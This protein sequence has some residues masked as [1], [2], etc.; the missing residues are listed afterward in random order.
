MV[1]VFLAAMM[2]VATIEGTGVQLLQVV[3]SAILL[4]VVAAQVDGFLAE[5]PEAD[6]ADMQASSDALTTLDELLDQP[7]AD[8]PVAACFF[9]AETRLAAGAAVF[10]GRRRSPV[11][12]NLA[13]INFVKGAGDG[14]GVLSAPPVLVTAKEGDLA[15]LRMSGDLA[16]GSPIKPKPAILRRSTSALLARRRGLRATTVVGQ[17]ETASD[18]ALDIIENVFSGEDDE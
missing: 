12:G 7:D 9:G 10:F 8:P 16:G 5:D 17:G 4:A 18:V 2:N 15:T 3:A 1:P 14:S 6:E 13:V 11:D